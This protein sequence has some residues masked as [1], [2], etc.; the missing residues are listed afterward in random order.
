[1]YQRKII[2]IKIR[3]SYLDMNYSNYLGILFQELLETE[4]KV[5]AGGLGGVTDYDK[6]EEKLNAATT[7]QEFVSVTKY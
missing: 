3:L 5:R 4:N 1:M 2:V 6:W 7:L